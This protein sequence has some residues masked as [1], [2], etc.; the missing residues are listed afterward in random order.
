MTCLNC[1]SLGFAQTPDVAL[2]I[3]KDTGIFYLAISTAY[4]L[5]F[6]Y[7]LWHSPSAQKMKKV[8]IFG[9]LMW[10][11]IGGALIIQPHIFSI[12]F[13]AFLVLLALLVLYQLQFTSALSAQA[14]LGTSKVKTDDKRAQFAQMLLKKGNYSMTDVLSFTLINEQILWMLILY[15]AA[16]TLRASWGL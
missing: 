13:N 7:M 14:T 12:F 16:M 1:E 5:S 10:A 11:F 15:R 3:I 9:I 8:H 6:L 4:L 2:R